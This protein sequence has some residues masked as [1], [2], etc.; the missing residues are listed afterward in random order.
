MN[1]NTSLIKKFHELIILIVPIILLITSQGCIKSNNE[2]INEPKYIEKILY[3]EGEEYIEE[4]QT[5]EILSIFMKEST[6]LIEFTVRATWQDEDDISN[7]RSY[8]NEPDTVQVYMD[9]KMGYHESGYGENSQGQEG[10]II[11]NYPMDDFENKR[12][13]G[14][15]SIVISAEIMFAGDQQPDIGTSFGSI[16]DR[17]NIVHCNCT[18]KVLAHAS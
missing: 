13:E 15:R 6:V 16:E 12:L 3:M 4:D 18:W 1:Y 2:K 5:K 9:D 7:R 11:V 10:E 17:G 8:T 14:A